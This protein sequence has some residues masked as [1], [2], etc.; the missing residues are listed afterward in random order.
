MGSQAPASTCSVSRRIWGE[1]SGETD[2][3]GFDEEGV[4]RFERV[5]WAED[6][7]DKEL[8]ACHAFDP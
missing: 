7:V 6:Q 5:V 2:P 3:V 8:A 1:G 4:S